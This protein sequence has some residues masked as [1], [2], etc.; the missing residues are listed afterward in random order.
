MVGRHAPL[1]AAL[2]VVLG[3][4]MIL[5]LI[6]ALGLIGFGFSMAGSL[7]L[8]LV[9]G[10]AVGISASMAAVAAQLTENA[11]VASISAFGPFYCLHFVR[12]ISNM[13]G[14]SLAW[15]GWLVPNGWLENV[16]PFASERW[17]IFGLVAIW[18]FVLLKLAFKLSAI[19]DLGAGMIPV[20]NGPAIAPSGLR[21]PMGLAWRL[22]RRMLFFWIG[23]VTFISLP[24]GLV[25]PKGLQEYAQGEWIQEYAATLNVAS[26]ADAFF[27][28][29]LFVMVFPIAM[30]A[31]MATLRMRSDEVDGS[32]EMI[33]T[34]AVNRWQWA[35]SHLTFGLVAPVILLI[36]MGLSFGIGSGIQSGDLSGDLTRMLTL[37]TSLIPA[38]WVIVGITMAAIGLF[39]RGSTVVGWT[40]LAV[41]IVTEIVVKMGLLPEWLFLTL[42]PFPHVNP[43]YQPT[44]TTLLVLTFLSAILISTGFYGLR[45]RDLTN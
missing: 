3:S 28:Y 17:W 36:I 7:A 39:G 6:T 16:R 42:S 5:T 40:S 31:I 15:L 22:Q 21:S 20:G 32:A 1:T 45:R 25:G 29:L 23:L 8:G 11:S 2:A 44:A 38:V 43:Y 9:V 27:T 19:R 4:G 18:V 41:G 33:L 24:T 14:E 12:G 13:G 30:Y 37:T 10:S 34:T 35:A 26:P